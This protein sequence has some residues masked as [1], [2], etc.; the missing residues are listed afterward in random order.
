MTNPPK[1]TALSKEPTPLSNEEK[2]VEELVDYFAFGAMMNPVS[3]KNRNIHPVS[4]EPAE[5]LDHRL[6][7]FTS[8]GYADFCFLNGWNANKTQEQLSEERQ[9]RYIC[10]WL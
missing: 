1:E 4:S 8:L 10:R 3:V 2:D 6:G 7:F 9:R 5:L